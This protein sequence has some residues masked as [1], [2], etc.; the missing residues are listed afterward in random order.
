MRA[1][2]FFVFGAHDAGKVPAWRDR[3]SAM[4]AGWPSAPAITK[5]PLCALAGN[6]RLGKHRRFRNVL[7][8][9]CG[10]GVLAIAAAKLWRVQVMASDIDPVAIE[11]A[12][13]NARANGEAP[14]VPRHDRRRPGRS[15]PGAWRSLRLIIANILAGPLTLLAPQIARALERRASAGPVGSADMAGKLVLSFYRDSGPC[16]APAAIARRW[17]WSALLLAVG[18]SCASR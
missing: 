14:F 15:Y 6:Q 2:R 9:G 3:R 12:R 1:G 13:D 16:A 17:R 4:E 10:T 11:V 18:W 8:L 5:R 7:D